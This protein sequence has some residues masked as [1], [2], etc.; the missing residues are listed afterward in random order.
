[1]LTKQFWIP[2]PF[3][4]LLLQG[5]KRYTLQVRGGGEFPHILWV[6]TFSCQP[7]MAP[8]QALEVLQRKLP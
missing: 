5:T 4:S 7:T 3:K 2:I 1:M 6:Q 8:P